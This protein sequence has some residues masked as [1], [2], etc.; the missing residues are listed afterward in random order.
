MS[1]TRSRGQNGGLIVTIWPNGVK[2]RLKPV[3]HRRLKRQHQRHKCW[4][5]CSFCDQEMLEYVAQQERSV[6]E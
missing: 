1:R 4:W 3:S 6:T 2:R 5:L